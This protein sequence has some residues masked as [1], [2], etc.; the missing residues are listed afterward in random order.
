MEEKKVYII[1]E[2]TSY[3]DEDILAEIGEAH[4]VLPPP[5]SPT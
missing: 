3:T 1:P 4:A 2:V 5:V